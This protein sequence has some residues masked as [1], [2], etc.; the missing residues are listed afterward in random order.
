MI[1]RSATFLARRQR[2]SGHGEG[3]VGSD[4]VIERGVRRPAAAGSSGSKPR[5]SA[6]ESAASY[7]LQDAKRRRRRTD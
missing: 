5:A 6:G 4:A 1:E 3:T 2:R 7:R